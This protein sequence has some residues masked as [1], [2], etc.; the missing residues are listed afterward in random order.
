M[1]WGKQM[2]SWRIHGLVTLNAGRTQ[3]LGSFGPYSDGPKLEKPTILE[4]FM[5]GSIV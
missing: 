1:Q 3:Y 5:A 4:P 2:L